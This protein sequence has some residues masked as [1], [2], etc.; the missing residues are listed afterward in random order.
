MCGSL[1]V[2]ACA[3]V[4]MC[5]C[6]YVYVCVCAGVCMW[7]RVY[8]YVR[9]CVCAHVHMCVVSLHAVNNIDVSLGVTA[10]Y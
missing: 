1:I 6:V 3:G 7:M 5:R 10:F 8:M 4:C 2:H 9:V